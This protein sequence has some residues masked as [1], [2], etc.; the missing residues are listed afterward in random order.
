MA[1]LFVVALIALFALQ[2]SLAKP[3]AK[4]AEKSPLEE[5]ARNTE[6]L[7]NN[8]T[9][10][11]GIKELPDSKKVVEILNTNAQTLANHVQEIVDKL[12]GEVKAH[13]GEI[14]NVIRQVEQ[15]LSETAANLQQAA[16]PEATAKAKE[17]KKNLDDGLKNAVAQVDKLVKAIEPDA[18]KAKTD[19]QNAAQTLLNQITEV[20]QNLQ[21]QVKASIAE[22]EKT[23]KH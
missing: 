5:L 23:H 21:T 3:K 8:V 4:Q 17:L 6:T 20:S 11:L 22:H 19:I 7:V 9:Q 16:G 18:T 13:Q 2:G 12:K 10:T 15:K 1:K 14:D